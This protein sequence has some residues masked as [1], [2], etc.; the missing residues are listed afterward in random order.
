MTLAQ[1]F[2][3]RK[4]LALKFEAAPRAADADGLA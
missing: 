1:G 3:Q 4:A 2:E